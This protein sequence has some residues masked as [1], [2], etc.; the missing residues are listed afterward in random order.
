VRPITGGRKGEPV[1]SV[2]YEVDGRT[3]TVPLVLDRDV[4]AAPM[5]WRLTHPIR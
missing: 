5:W 4:L 2:R 3:V 1:G